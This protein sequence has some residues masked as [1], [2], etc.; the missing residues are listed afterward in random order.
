MESQHAS[1]SATHATATH[2]RVVT[3]ALCVLS[4]DPSGLPMKWIHW[5]QAAS[6][7]AQGDQ[8]WTYG[9]PIAFARGGVNS[10]GRQSVIELPPVIASR[11]PARHRQIAD[12]PH[13]TNGLL[14]ARDQHVCLYCGNR[15]AMSALSRDHV[16]PRCLGGP[17]AWE[18]VVTACTRCNHR[19]GGRRP[20][21]AGMSLLAVPYAPSYA[22][23]LILS[24]RRILADQMQFLISHVPSSRRAQMERYIHVAEPA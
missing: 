14:F 17:D 18:N 5:T 22:E 19:K 23:K 21:E 12:R 11:A 7:L 10:Q 24:G 8:A 16:V 4:V 6:V 3:H 1:T 13:L 15:H 20:E 2:M 9:E